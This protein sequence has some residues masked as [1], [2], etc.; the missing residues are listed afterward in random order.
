MST[1]QDTNSTS[2]LDPAAPDGSKS[3]TNTT[4][5]TEEILRAKIKTLESQ[6]QACQQEI[7]RL[8]K[9]YEDVYKTHKTYSKV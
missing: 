5:I 8:R 3:A 9:F 7:A 1:T 2:Q 6:L 4:T